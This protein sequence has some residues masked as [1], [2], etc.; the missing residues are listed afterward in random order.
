LNLDATKLEISSGVAPMQRPAIPRA[1][2]WT[3]SEKKRKDQPNSAQS[4]L[5]FIVG[6]APK[7]SPEC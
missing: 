3:G 2:E 1:E 4:P 5:Q 6:G 7:K